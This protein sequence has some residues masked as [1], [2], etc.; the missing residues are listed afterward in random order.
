MQIRPVVWALAQIVVNGDRGTIIEILK[1]RHESMHR[2]GQLC[3]RITKPIRADIASI[4]PFF[5]ASTA[6]YTMNGG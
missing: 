3:D 4:R 2:R 1:A 5:P 6:S